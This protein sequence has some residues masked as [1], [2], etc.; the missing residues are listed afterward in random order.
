M[1]GFPG[2]EIRAERVRIG[3]DVRIGAGTVLVADELVLGDGA[4]VEQGCDLR[5]ARLELA[6]HA[7][8]GQGSRWLVAERARLGAGSVVDADAQVQCLELSVGDETYVGQRWRVGGG[9]SMEPRSTVRVGDRC[10]IAPDVLVNPTEP[11][12][13]GD[14]VGISAQVAIFTHGYHAGHAVRHGHGAAFAGVT[15]GDGVWLGFRAVLLP[16]VAVGAGSIVAAAAAV[17]KPVPASVLAGGVPA[18]VIRRLSPASLDPAERT[19]AA[20]TA[21]HEWLRRLEFKGFAVAPAAC[22]DDDRVA[23]RWT[24]SRDD[25][26]WR[27]ARVRPADAAGPAAGTVE[28]ADAT[29]GPPVPAAAVFDFAEPLQVRGT[30][31]ELGHDLREHLRRATWLFRYGR[32]SRGLVP[33]RFARL[34]DPSPAAP[35]ACPPPHRAGHGRASR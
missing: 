13:I 6:E 28:I 8:V 11:V 10:Q 21:V 22:P 5:S 3:Q 2:V 34:L 4:V 19:A 25:R 32:N 17:A 24:V 30:L 26:C 14:E 23:G 1:N 31:D 9:A 29:A 33:Q 27:I 35:A 15:V 7:R 12:V 16:G 20:D 18:R